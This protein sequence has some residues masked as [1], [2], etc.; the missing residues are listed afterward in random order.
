MVELLGWA[1]LVG[2]T[3]VGCNCYSLTY[4]PRLPVLNSISETEMYS[5]VQLALKN[6][7][8]HPW[9]S[10]F[11]VYGRQILG[12]ILP[13]QK[14]FFQYTQFVSSLNVDII[15]FQEV[16]LEV[17]HQ[18]QKGADHS[19]RGK[20]TQPQVTQLSKY[21]PGFQY[22]YQPA[23]LYTDRLPER[24]EEGVAIFSRYPLLSSDYILLF[25]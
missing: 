11:L 7:V 16:R 17:F 13:Y 3:L 15:G 4:I 19:G 2:Q 8:I 9:K 14:L 24:S 6:S 21:F 5:G 23:M 25:R 1:R 12:E 18:A 20:T 22:V 10:N